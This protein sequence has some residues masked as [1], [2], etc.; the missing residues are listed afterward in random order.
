MAIF[1]DETIASNPKSN[2]S[3]TDFVN[4]ITKFSSILLDQRSAIQCD[5]LEV[6]S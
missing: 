1:E 2:H 4:T 6:R 5:L 3:I